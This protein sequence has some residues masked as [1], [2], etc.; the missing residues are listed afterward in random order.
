MIVKAANQNRLDLNERQQKV[1][2]LLSEAIKYA[3][4]NDIRIQYDQQKKQIL[5]L[6]QTNQIINTQFLQDDSPLQMIRDIAKGI[7]IF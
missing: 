2:S 6:S 5:Y 4:Y 7:K 3:S 1:I